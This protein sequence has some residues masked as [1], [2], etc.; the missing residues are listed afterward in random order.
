MSSWPRMASAADR[1]WRGEGHRHAHGLRLGAGAL[2]DH[3][4]AVGLSCG[5][6]AVAWALFAVSK[7]APVGADA[8]MLGPVALDGF[9]TSA[10]ATATVA[11]VAVVAR[12]CM[13]RIAVGP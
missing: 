12:A 9:A 10:A 11:L 8:A 2:A 4:A 3:Y 1:P 7:G 6:V 13:T 5:G